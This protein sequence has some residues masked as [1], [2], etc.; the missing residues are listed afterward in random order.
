MKTK[1]SFLTIAITCLMYISCYSQKDFSITNASQIVDDFNAD[2]ILPLDKA[3]LVNG[4]VEVITTQHE[5]VIFIIE[6]G[7]QNSFYWLQHSPNKSKN[8]IRES[9]DSAQVI[10]FRKNLLIN[11]LNSDSRFLFSINGDEELPSYLSELEVGK[12]YYGNGLAHY[13]TK[14]EF[15]H[16]YIFDDYHGT[17]TI[18][19]FLQNMQN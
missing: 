14:D 4:A 15:N 1:F 19:D 2:K 16:E 13:Y 10:F 11:D 3:T 18:D 7:K 8:I 12:I 9:I 17:E 5:I 6:N